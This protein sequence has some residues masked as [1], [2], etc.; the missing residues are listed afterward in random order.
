MAFGES[1]GSV[2]DRTSQV[3]RQQNWKVGKLGETVFETT[4]SPVA[5]SILYIFEVRPSS[6]LEKSD[7]DDQTLP[8]KSFFP[9]VSHFFTRLGPTYRRHTNV[10]DGFL[11]DKLA[12]SR[13]KAK[14]LGMSTTSFKVRG[15]FGQ[16]E[17][18][19]GNEERLKEARRKS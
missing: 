14:T 2:L 6:S 7:A 4:D 8:L 10:L 15:T 3:E 11:K 19:E 16:I 5:V 12:A 9:A 17:K 13:A 1:F 18:A